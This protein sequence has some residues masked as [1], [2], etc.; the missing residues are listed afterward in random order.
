MSTPHATTII[1]TRDADKNYTGDYA[2]TCEACPFTATRR[3]LNAA[4]SAAAKHLTAPENLTPVLS[5]EE[6]DERKAQ[7]AEER[8]LQAVEDANLSIDQARAAVARAADKIAE[9]S[10]YGM[11]SQWSYLNDYLNAVAVNEIWQTVVRIAGNRPVDQDYGAALAEAVQDVREQITR[12]LLNNSY[13]ASS[14]DP[15]SN[16]A[17]M[18]KTEVS[19]HWLQWDSV[20]ILAGFGLKG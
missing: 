20:R 12:D 14:S 13:R 5:P 6:Q 4:N 10:Q 7:R 11:S 16:A 2:V 18:V 8:R 17:Q 3:S 1:R 15:V 19:S 9:A